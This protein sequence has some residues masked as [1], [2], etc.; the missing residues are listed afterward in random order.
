MC[1]SHTSYFDSKV[2]GF[3]PEQFSKK[4]Q[5]EVISGSPVYTMAEFSTVTKV[6]ADLLTL[7]AVSSPFPNIAPGSLVVVKCVAD[8]CTRQLPKPFTLGTTLA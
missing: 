8:I 2:E 1:V 3:L 6:A 4:F 5:R 7:M